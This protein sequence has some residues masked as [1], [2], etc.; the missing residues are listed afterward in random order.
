MD[1]SDDMKMMDTKQCLTI[2]NPVKTSSEYEQTIR[3]KKR[4]KIIIII[5]Y[6]LF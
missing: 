3:K 1:K 4:K 5:C 6:F 2:G